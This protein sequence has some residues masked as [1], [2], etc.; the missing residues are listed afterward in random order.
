MGSECVK[1]DYDSAGVEIT[2]TKSE[3]SIEQASMLSL[4]SHC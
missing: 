1:A 3:H 4:L 2:C